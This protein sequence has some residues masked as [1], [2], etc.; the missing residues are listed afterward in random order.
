[1]KKVFNIIKGK[2]KLIIMPVI[3]LIVLVAIYVFNSAQKNDSAIVYAEN[4]TFVEASGIV[5]NNLISVSSEVTGTVIETIADEGDIIKKG[6]LIAKIENT[7]LQNQY[8]QALINVQVAEKNILMLENSISNLTVQNANAVQQAHNAYLSAEAEYKKVIDGASEDEI[9]QA[10]EAVSQA[11]TN[12]EYAKTNIERSK[13]LFNEKAISQSKYDEAVKNYNVSEAQYNAALSQL[14]LIKSYPT[15]ASRE[16]AENKML[17][18]KAGYE[19]SISNGNTQ[20]SQLEGQLDIAMVQLEQSKDIVEQ[21]ERELEKLTIKSPFDGVVNSLLVKEGELV[22]MGKLIAEIYNPENIEINSYVSETNIGRI[23][24][25]QYVAIS[26]DSHDDKLFSGKVTRIN[27][28]AEFTPKN[29]QTKEERV[30]TVFEVTIKV[31]DSNGE[32][33]PGMP[34]DVNIKID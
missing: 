20:I 34:V 29:I 6:G 8:N 9:K 21:T 1:M 12:F 31:L 33:K 2:G 7:S 27:N 10:E 32:I 22:S 4:G 23:M 16:A 14:N 18:L 25:G 3:I 26:I 17:Q 19:L 13:E 28:R 15:D 30:N 11:K 24:V 5:E